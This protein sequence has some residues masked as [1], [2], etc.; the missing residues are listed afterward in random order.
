MRACVWFYYISVCS[1]VEFSLDW[2]AHSLAHAIQTFWYRIFRFH[3]FLLHNLQSI[4]SDIDLKN[5]LF[6]ATIRQWWTMQTIFTP[7]ATCLDIW[8]LWYGDS[9]FP[10]TLSVRSHFPSRLVCSIL[11]FKCYLF[12]MHPIK[13]CVQ[14]GWWWWKEV[15]ALR[16]WTIYT[17]IFLSC[18]H[19]LAFNI[20][21]VNV[22]EMKCSLDQ[23]LNNK[24]N[25]IRN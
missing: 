3:F 1:L 2:L 9:F 15:Y 4:F 8:T 10:P 16:Q 20:S 18:S 7:F 25:G 12:V 21:Y 22:L 19:A 11:F 13:I 24:S 23:Q 5:M 17:A 14:Y 6:V